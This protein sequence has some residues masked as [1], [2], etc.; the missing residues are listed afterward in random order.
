MKA[1]EG[2]PAIGCITEKRRERDRKQVRWP[3]QSVTRSYRKLGSHLIKRRKGQ[4][5]TGKDTSVPP[6]VGKKDII[7]HAGS[8]LTKT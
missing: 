3:K 5:N 8:P 7:L 2:I 1:M 4:K 6:N